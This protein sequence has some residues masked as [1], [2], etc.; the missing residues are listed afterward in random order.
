MTFV[1]ANDTVQY[2]QTVASTVWNFDHNL[3]TNTPAVTVW[4]NQ[5]SDLVVMIPQSILV[6]GPNTIKVEFSSPQSGT[7]VVS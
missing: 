1:K 2:T 5:G 4:V 7:L 6:I 3:C